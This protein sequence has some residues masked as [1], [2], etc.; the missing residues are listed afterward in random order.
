MQ[1]FDIM[2]YINDLPGG[3][4][5]IIG[6]FI[7]YILDFALYILKDKYNQR[8]LSKLPSESDKHRYDAIMDVAK[9]DYFYYFKETPLTSIRSKAIYNI[10]HCYEN[11]SSIRKSKPRYENK[12]LQDLEDRF[13][14]SLE[15]I[16]NILPDYMFPK[17]SNPEIFTVFPDGNEHEKFKS[18]RC[19]IIDKIG[20]LIENYNMFRDEGNKV[21]QTKI[22]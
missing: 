2:K 8:K 11:I 1:K 13:F 4:W 3:A 10:E 16:Y 9:P 14:C 6:F 18:H 5:A 15:Y 19:E 20:E 17:K 21:F 7:T 22:K 12:K